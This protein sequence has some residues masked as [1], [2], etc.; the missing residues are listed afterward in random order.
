MSLRQ[1]VLVTVASLLLLG[2]VLELIRRHRL[3]EKYALAWLAIALAAA[4]SPWL[5]GFYARLAR[6]AGII[7]P[8]SLFFFLAI[9]GLLLLCLQFSLALT[10]AHTQRKILAQQAALLEE[11]VR[12]LESRSGPPPEAGPPS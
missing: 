8:S 1:V 10:S 4:T 11:R 5:F 3:R 6:V 12:R 2:L 7:D 9:F